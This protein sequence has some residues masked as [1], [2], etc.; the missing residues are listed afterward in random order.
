[1][2]SIVSKLTTIFNEKKH[3]AKSVAISMLLILAAST[4]LLPAS[5]PALAQQPVVRLIL[6]WSDGCPHC[7]DVIDHVLPPL[8]AKYGDQME[9]SMIEIASVE[10]FDSLLQVAEAYGLTRQQVG[11]PFMVI[12][13]RVLIGSDQ[14]PA[15]LPGLME[16]HLAAG[17]LDLPQIPALEGL[18]PAQESQP[19]ALTHTNTPPVLPVPTSPAA[20][21]EVW[22]VPQPRQNTPAA[23]SWQ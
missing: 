5:Q 23:S 7:H 17:G 9:I 13:D 16:R 1:M 4:S 12:G 14:I 3:E 6:F 19:P 18:L 8:K 10:D 21:V 2:N 20:G 22:R 15:E 11:V